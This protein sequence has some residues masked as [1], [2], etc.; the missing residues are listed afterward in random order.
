MAGRRCSSCNKMCSVELSD[1]E[2]DLNVTNDGSGGAEI[3]G[4][5]ELRLESSCC[6]EEVATASVEV[7][8]T[9]EADQFEHLETCDYWG[10]PDKEGGERELKDADV[11]FDT[12]DESAEPDDWYEGTDPKTGKPYSMRYQRHYY[13]ANVT[14]G[15]VCD[16]CGASA[17]FE[18]R[19]GE[20]ASS[21]E[22]A[23]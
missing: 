8:G 14:V 16:S 21:F 17:T 15:V 18:E 5:V 11:G 23:Y 19:V 3:S 7:D 22:E 2:F 6:S 20:Q 4:T 9:I 12:S 10:E 13:G 1:P